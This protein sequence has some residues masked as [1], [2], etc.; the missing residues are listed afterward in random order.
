MPAEALIYI[1]RKL[2]LTSLAPTNQI[3]PRKF[4][5]QKANP[6]SHKFSPKSMQ[7][8]PRTMAVWACL[9]VVV[10]AC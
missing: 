6:T 10:G 1:S 3:K 4:P 7:V 8:A 2:N 5:L 9:G